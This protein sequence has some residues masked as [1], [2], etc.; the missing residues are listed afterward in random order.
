ME[1]IIM[2]PIAIIHRGLYGSFLKKGDLNITS[3]STV[4]LIIGIPQKYS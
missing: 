2:G 3:R 1:T 4:I